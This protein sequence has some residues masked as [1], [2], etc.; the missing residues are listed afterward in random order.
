LLSTWHC[1]MGNFS[2]DKDTKYRIFLHDSIPTQYGRVTSIAVARCHSY[3]YVL[4]SIRTFENLKLCLSVG[5]W[6]IY[7][8]IYIYIRCA[9]QADGDEK[10]IVMFIAYMTD[11][12][13]LMSSTDD[14]RM[15]LIRRNTFRAGRASCIVASREFRPIIANRRHRPDARNSIAL[16]RPSMS[17]NGIFFGFKVH[18]HR[19]RALR[20]VYTIRRHSPERPSVVRLC[21]FNFELRH[22]C[23]YDEVRSFFSEDLGRFSDE[24]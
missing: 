21:L 19:A 17:Q 23:L 22:I 6:Y 10:H 4:C 2:T 24:M 8:Y 1:T 14:W 3:M 11:Y 5:L 15:S 7:I 12:T 13:A 16:H 20:Y 9:S 18:S